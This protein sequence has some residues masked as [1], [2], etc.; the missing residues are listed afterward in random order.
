MITQIFR[1]IDGLLRQ[2][3]DAHETSD[4]ASGEQERHDA[5][6]PASR[7]A[8]H[9][10]R[11]VC[12]SRSTVQQRDNPSIHP[13]TK[14][15]LRTNESQNTSHHAHQIKPTSNTRQ[16]NQPAQNP[17]PQKIYMATT[18][19]NQAI[20]MDSRQRVLIATTTCKTGTQAKGK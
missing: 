8:R 12:L 5:T 1:A 9:H 17:N 19:G 16:T 20:A 7:V 18:I 10:H 11:Y 4:D 13:T 15:S 3:M 14:P 6:T 2:K